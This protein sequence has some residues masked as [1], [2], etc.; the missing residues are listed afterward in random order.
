MIKEAI[1]LAGG[2]GTRLQTVV[3]DVPKPMAPING[4]PFLDYLVKYLLQFGIQK[5][6]FSVGYKSTAIMEYFG[7][8]FSSMEIDYAKEE[9]P[10][11]TG[12]GLKNAM[13][14]CHTD[15][16]LV[17]NGDTFLELDFND[18]YNFHQKGQAEV[19]L[20]LRHVDNAQRYGTV[21]IDKEQNITGFKEKTGA[22]SPGL[23]NGGVYI[24]QRKVWNKFNLP[25]KFSLEKDF[26]EP[27]LKKLKMMGY[28]SSGYFID[29]GIPEDYQKAK[30]DF[31]RFES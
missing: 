24:F 18:F 8:S 15:N 3:S 10:L 11:G 27:N 2:L 30:D 28:V 9:E 25:Q 17:L 20:C 26:F 23:I 13:E 14:K 21:S 1:I 19:S 12:G 16:I 5:I 31:K 6:V 29:I 4:K 7:N 22:E